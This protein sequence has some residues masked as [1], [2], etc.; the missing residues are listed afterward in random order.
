MCS[1]DLDAYNDRIQLFAAD[2]KFLRKWGGFLALNISGSRPGWFKTATAVA[3]GPD[4][5][6]FTADFYNNRVQ[7]FS[8]DGEFL[9]VIGEEG[10]GPGQLKLPTDIALDEAGNVYVVDFGN[11]R[12]VKFSPQ[13]KK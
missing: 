10:S 9:S 11:Y 13:Y 8:R 7:K 5:T 2:G 4:Q 3:V 12:I 6:I 1:S